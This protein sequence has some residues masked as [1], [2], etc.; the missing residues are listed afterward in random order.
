[1]KY[2]AVI[3]ISFVI[4]SCNEQV[5]KVYVSVKVLDEKGNGLPE[6]QIQFNGQDTIFVIKTDFEGNVELQSLKAG[7]YKVDVS[8]VGY[9]SLEDYSILIDKDQQLNFEMKSFDLEAPNVEWE[10]GWITF[11]DD[12]GKIR[13]I[14]IKE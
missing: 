7:N 8:Y 1:M 3:L 5:N 6:S 9:Y 13:S 11:E 10:G 4:S 2:L 12:N 14:K